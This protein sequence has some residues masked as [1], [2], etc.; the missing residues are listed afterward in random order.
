[1][2]LFIAAGGIAALLIIIY[3]ELVRKS[4]QVK[5]TFSLI[6]VYLKQ[7]FDLLPNL[8][9][10]VK[11]HMGHERAVME[12]LTALRTRAAAPSMNPEAKIELYNELQQ[13][14]RQLFVS[15]ENYPVLQSSA[16][17]QQLQ[18]TWSGTEENIA[19]ARRTY[20]AAVTRFN[21]Y[22]QQ[23]PVNII[24]AIL[25]FQPATLLETPEAERTNPNAKNL[26]Q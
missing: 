7:R 16:L 6:D 4:N 15:V 19:A 2:Y 9:E 14:A 10:I 17:F 11:Q 13:A 8:V 18:N 1:M 23:F 24:N 21:T 20:N 26:F 3:N 25:G 22:Q 12:N 5:E